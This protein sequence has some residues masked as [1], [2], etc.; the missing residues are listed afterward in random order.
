MSELTLLQEVLDTPLLDQRFA[1]L[2]RKLVRPEH[3]QKVIESYRRLCKLL[4]LEVQRIER[5]GSALVPEVD[6]SIIRENGGLLPEGLADTV[7][8]RGCVILRGV[9]PEEQAVAWE[10]SLKDYVKRHPGVGGHPVEKPAAWNIYWTKAQVEMRSHPNIL[11]AM[12]S[13]SRLWK[14]SD[15]NI[16]IDLDSQVVYP[17]RIRIRYPTLQPGQFPLLPHLDSGGIERWEDE[18][19]RQNFRKIFEGNWQDW[20]AWEADH[21][22]D[23][24][25][26]LYQMGI[27]CSA[28]RSLQGWLSLSHTG[29][30]EGTLR[31][32][33]NLKLSMAYIMLRPLFHATGEFDDSLPTFPGSTPGDTQFFPTNEG[34][35]HLNIDKAII[36]IPPVKP[37]DYVFWHCDLVHGVDEL[38]PGKNDSSVFYNACTPLTPY[39][40]E[41]LIGSRAAFE[42]GDVPPDFKRIEG[43]REYMHADCGSRREYVLSESGLRA[44][45]LKEFDE[46]EEGLEVG[47]REVR[48]LANEKLGF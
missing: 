31:L 17:D 8:E 5:H 4:E 34:H 35:P 42:A 12:R 40:V 48:R 1:D 26:D 19:N 24:N 36:G 33:P 10:A 43:E 2:K 9:V 20:D 32:L 41:S 13:V 38:N 16:P 27:S 37:G 3:K 7:R 6:F 47:Q 46:D 30:G 22:V 15:P 18:K 23:A 45:G 21:R 39:N 11:E 44:L 28:W 25:S 14:V 29:T